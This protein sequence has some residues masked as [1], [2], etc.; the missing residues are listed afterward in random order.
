VSRV[1][2]YVSKMVPRKVQTLYEAE[3]I[4][5]IKWDGGEFA[6]ATIPATRYPTGLKSNPP[7]QVI[8]IP[9]SENYRFHFRAQRVPFLG[10]DDEF[11]RLQEFLESTYP[12]TWWIVTGS[13]GLGKSRLAL[14]LCKRYASSWH[15]GFLLLNHGFESYWHEWQPK[16]PTLII[17][18]YIISRVEDIHN[19]LV[20]LLSRTIP[21]NWPVRLLLL[22]R[23]IKSA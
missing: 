12:L 20:M 2:E 13:G 3:Q 1:F 21:L 23:E 6:V 15:T 22:E 18:D 9:T 17:V 4:P 7:L 8:P 16:Q 11:Q 14:E 5:Q 19:I 10:R